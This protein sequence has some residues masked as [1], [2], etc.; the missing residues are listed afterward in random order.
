MIDIFENP[1]ARMY[2]PHF[3]ILYISLY[4]LIL[5]VVWFLLPIMTSGTKLNEIPKIPNR[6]DPYELAYLRGG[7]KEVALLSIYSLI[8]KNFIRLL[9]NNER[10][11]MAIVIR[12][13]DVNYGLLEQSEKII[14][15]A[16]PIEKDIVELIENKILMNEIKDAMY[17]LKLRL[18]AD[19]I[20]CAEKEKNKFKYLKWFLIALLISFGA[21]KLF[22]AYAHGH[23][24][25]VL[26]FATA[27]IGSMFINGININEMLTKKGKT[28][29]NSIK[30]IFESISGNSLFDQPLYMQQLLISLYGFK[31][32][33]E[34]KKEH[35]YTYLKTNISPSP[36]V[37]FQDNYSSNGSSSCG[38][39]SGCGGGC[40]GCGGCS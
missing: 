26:I 35:F 17:E 37:Y 32:L 9:T 14:Y 25:V 7:E 8:N 36:V 10:S 16:I 24:N 22:A 21:Y 27:M 2:G 39:G 12:D 29:I 3:L 28:L 15:E 31:L 1:L 5:V 38:G 18:V 33:K 23:K 34:S 4:L 6:P 40:G 20:L 30:N 19:G 11:K 13:K